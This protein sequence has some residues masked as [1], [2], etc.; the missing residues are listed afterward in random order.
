MNSS[1]RVT[2]EVDLLAIQSAVR[3]IL[4][5]VGE[6]PERPGLEETPRRVASMYAEMFSGL[7]LD[8]ARHLSVT[9]PEQYDEMVLIRDIQFTSMCEHHLLPFNGVAHVAYILTPECEILNLRNKAHAWQRGA[10]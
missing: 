4:K 5:A 3:T 7:H 9:F 10:P 2:P 8:P 1:D 6:D